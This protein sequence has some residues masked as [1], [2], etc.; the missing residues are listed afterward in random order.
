MIYDSHIHSFFSADSDSSIDDICNTAIKRNIDG[1][2]LTDHLDLYYPDFDVEF[3]ID[4]KKYHEEIAKYKKKYEDKLKIFAGLELG[5][6]T[7]AIEESSQIVN[8][9]NFDFVICSVHV[10]QGEDPY[11]GKYFEGK[12]KEEAYRIYLEKVY[13]SIVNQPDYDVIGHLGY[14]RRYGFVEDNSM[15]YSEYSD[16]LEP[17]L[18][19]L[20]SLGK[21]IEL[22]TSYFKREPYIKMPEKD[23]LLKYKELGGE[24]I[25]IGSDAHK[26][27]RVGI[28]FSE[29][30]ELL[31]ECGFQYI[32]H[33]EQRKP[34]FTNI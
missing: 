23:I 9:H 12:T 24:I 31:K 1:I 6:R 28:N 14:I 10:I 25:T 4:F 17:I 34:I 2:T 8:A 27:D 21:G 7:K 13:K 19:K 5:Y 18:K 22:N 3:N 16:L 26:P 20:I 29:G 30:I 33:F 15:N 11:H 32:A